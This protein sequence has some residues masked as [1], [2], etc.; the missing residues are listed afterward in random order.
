MF[1]FSDVIEASSHI[2]NG[3]T[4]NFVMLQIA[5][6]KC[7]LSFGKGTN[8]MYK[9]IELVPFQYVQSVVNFIQDKCEY[10]HMFALQLCPTDL[11]MDSWSRFVWIFGPLS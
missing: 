10:N 4:Y 3:Q 8:K 1:L 9:H 6:R 5:K 7:T 2:S 11:Y